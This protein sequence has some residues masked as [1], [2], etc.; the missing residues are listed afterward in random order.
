MQ[1][2]NQVNSGWVLVGAGFG[3]LAVIIV[4]GMLIARAVSGDGK[5]S[6]TPAR[7]RRVFE[8]LNVTFVGEGGND[9][10]MV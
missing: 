5:P 10:E 6:G 2:G 1:L 8:P 3:A 9:G 7:R 4:V